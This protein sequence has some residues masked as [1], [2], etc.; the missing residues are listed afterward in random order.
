MRNHFVF[1]ALLFG[2]SLCLISSV[3][4]QVGLVRM[5]EF[6]ANNQSYTNANGTITDVLELYNL[7][8]VPVDLAG[9]RLTDT[10]TFPNRYIFPPGSIIPANGFYRLTFATGAGSNATTVPFG[11]SANGGFLY[12]IS[13][14]L[15]IIDSIEYG[16][17]PVDYSMGRVADG[18]GP[19]VLCTPTLGAPNVATAVVGPRNAIKVNEWMV[20][21][22]SGDDYIELFN[23]TNKPVDISGIYISDKDSDRLQH[24]VPQRSYIGTGPMGGFQQFD[25]DNDTDPYPA[26]EIPFG[27]NDSGDL[28]VLTDT[29][30]VT[31]IDR[32]T[33]G[34]Q[35]TGVSQGRLPDGSANI[36]FFP[37]INDY[38]TASPGDPNYLIFTN[39]YI[40]EILPHT[41]PPLEDAVE[42]Q[43]R[44][45]GSLNING[46]WLS[47]GRNNRKKYRLPTAAPTPANGFR[48]I[49]E[50]VGTS[51]GFNSSSTNAVQPFTFNSARGDQV[52][53]S[54][55]DGSGNLTGY[56]VYESF[57]PSANAV[58]F[59]HYRTSVSNDYKF[60]AI[61]QRSFGVDDPNTVLEFRTGT[62]RTNPY[63]RVGPLV[64]NEI[65]FFPSNTTYIDTNGLLTTASNPL[66]EYVEIWNITSQT[67]PLYDPAYPTNQWRLQG[68][69]DFKFPITNLAPNQFCLVVAFDP[70]TNAS[71]LNNFRVRF[72][73][74][75][76]VPIFGPWT[77]TLN[78]DG[79]SVEIYRPD[80]PQAPGRPDAGLVPYIRVDKINYEDGAPWPPVTSGGISTG[81]TLQRR[82]PL[83]FGNDPINWA[84]DNPTAGRASAG[85]V[86][87]TDGDGMPDDWEMQ[88]SF[89]K[90]SPADAGGDAD[91]DGL[92][93]LGEFVA[94]THPRN[95]LSVLK[96]AQ[97]LPFDGTNRL[98]RFQAYSN[99]TYTVQSRNALQPNSDWNRVT[100]IPSATFHRMVDAIDTNAWSKA[101]RYYRVVAPA[102]Q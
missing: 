72:N 40:N 101:D 94:G 99:T 84:A 76:N 83:L 90:N 23:S 74:P 66:E 96:I 95:P 91:L 7:N 39:I 89:D 77:G 29:D 15:V 9:C 81:R 10:N 97:I 13:P 38:D 82:N 80:P 34:V 93:N 14:G 100:N 62:G 32:V 48:V 60:V 85:T 6:I 28:L 35:T 18:T 45:G 21:P 78:N 54:Q 71:A 8:N 59:G 30:Q 67:V 20:R 2:L 31:T 33:W 12:F 49:Y 64:V 19:W 51:V 53:L 87:D 22:S 102:T 73:V 65:M 98:I 68:G 52:V 25:S 47:N 69:I 36:V 5:N 58:S 86:L 92:T 16:L 88:Y 44:T 56:I 42:I 50:G 1:R 24:R 57:E 4:A 75:F 79:E 61:S 3:Q 17:Q 46:W 63:P 43:N 55:V 11:I 70:N 37:K 26:N 41:D 27:L